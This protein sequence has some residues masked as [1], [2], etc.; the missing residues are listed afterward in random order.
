MGIYGRFKINVKLERLIVE[1]AFKSFAQLLLVCLFVAVFCL[2]FNHE[3]ST[4]S[5]E[6][7]Q[8]IAAYVIDEVTKIPENLFKSFRC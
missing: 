2:F 5:G 1:K 7:Q 6:T 4:N 3:C 8:K